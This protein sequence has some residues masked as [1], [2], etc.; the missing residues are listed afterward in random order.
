[1]TVTALEFIRRFAL[2]ILPK[3]FVRIR[4]YGILSSKIKAGALPIIRAQLIPWV[5]EDPMIPGVTAAGIVTRTCPCCKKGLM[6]HVM[7]FDHRGPPAEYL[8]LNEKSE[9]NAALQQA[10]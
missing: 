6:Q 2:H 5:P 7:D 8:K 1:M 3:R 9:N 10:I 4:H